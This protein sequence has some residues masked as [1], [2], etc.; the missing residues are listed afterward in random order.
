MAAASAIQAT[1]LVE[2][3]GI[4]EAVE[5]PEPVGVLGVMVDLAKGAAADPLA[6]SVLAITAISFQGTLPLGLRIELH[7]PL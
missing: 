1:R 7:H 5:L 2:L 4:L 3:K 6:L